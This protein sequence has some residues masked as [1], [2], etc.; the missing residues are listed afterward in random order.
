MVS[1]GFWLWFASGL[2]LEPMPRQ[3]LFTVVEY[4]RV[5]AGRPVAQIEPALLDL[6]QQVTTGG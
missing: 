1:I 4:A 2:Y 6:A 5:K 3:C